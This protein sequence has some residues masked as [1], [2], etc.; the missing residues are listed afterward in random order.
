MNRFFVLH[1]QKEEPTRP[2]V[3]FG[4]GGEKCTGND[5]QL[6]EMRDRLL[7]DAVIGLDNSNELYRRIIHRNLHYYFGGIACCFVFS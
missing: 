6:R 1:V 7:P 3:P 4:T 5:V 2:N